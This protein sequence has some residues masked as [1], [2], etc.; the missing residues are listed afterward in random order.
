MAMDET[1]NLIG[2][3]KVQGTAVYGANDEKI[4][5]I[6]SLMIE[7][8]SGK[9]AYAVLGFGGILGIG[10]DHYPLIMTLFVGESAPASGQFF[11][12]GHNSMAR[13]MAAPFLMSTTIHF[14]IGSKR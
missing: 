2:S 4:G 1:G 10:D 9:V 12:D 5:S 11:Y 7:K 3:D 14:S 8:V 13:F 6:S